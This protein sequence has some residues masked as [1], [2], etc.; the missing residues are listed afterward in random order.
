[1]AP[2]GF[3]ELAYRSALVPLFGNDVSGRAMAAAA[4]LVGRRARIDAVYVLRVPRQLRLD[5]SLE[6]EEQVARNVLE[7]ARLAARTEKLKVRTSIIRTRNPGAAIVEEAKRLNAEVI[8][9]ATEHAPANERALG[10]T[11]MYLLEKRPCR[12]VI[13]TMGGGVRTGSAPRA[14]PRARAAD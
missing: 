6:H 4:K 11:A 5:A 9:L 2:E 14:R 7:T 13:E 10:A 8:Y 1:M 12:V 3:H